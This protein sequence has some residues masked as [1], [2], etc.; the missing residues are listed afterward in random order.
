MGNIGR[1]DECSVRCC[2]TKGERG[3]EGELTEGEG[4]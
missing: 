3:E 2:E 4:G 1:G